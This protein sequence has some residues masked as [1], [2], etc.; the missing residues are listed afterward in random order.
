MHNRAPRCGQ[1][2]LKRENSLQNPN[3]MPIAM[4][5][6]ISG[7]CPRELLYNEASTINKICRSHRQSRLASFH[8]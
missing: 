1:E 5:V 2:I 3:Q 6:G 8:S 4:K 7:V